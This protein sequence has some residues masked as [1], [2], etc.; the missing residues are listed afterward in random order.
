VSADPGDF[1][2]EVEAGQ[3]V[4]LALARGTVAL[5]GAGAWR[6]LLLIEGNV[7]PPSAARLRGGLWRWEEGASGLPAGW[8]EEDMDV[9]RQAFA[10]LPACPRPLAH[11]ADLG[12]R[13]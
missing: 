12:R 1:L 8:L 5:D 7:L 13:S 10:P 2:L 4:R 3:G 6:G 11:L 9:R